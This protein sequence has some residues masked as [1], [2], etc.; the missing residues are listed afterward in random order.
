[1][2]QLLSRIGLCAS[3]SLL[4]LAAVTSVQAE[5]NNAKDKQQVW[6]EVLSQPVEQAKLDDASQSADTDKLTINEQRELIR[7]GM[8]VPKT[9]ANDR[10]MEDRATFPSSVAK[11]SKTSTKSMADDKGVESRDGTIESSVERY[12]EPA[13]PPGKRSKIVD[14]YIENKSKKQGFLASFTTKRANTDLRLEQHPPSDIPL[15]AKFQIANFGTYI[16]IGHEPTNRL[17]GY[18]VDFFGFN[19]VYLE[20]DYHQKEDFWTRWKIAPSGQEDWYLI[21]SYVEPK[22]CLAIGMSEGLRL[23]TCNIND[24]WQQFRFLREKADAFW[25]PKD[26]GVELEIL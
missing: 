6:D 9:K 17:I 19:H 16:R 18:H 26:E 4:S 14:I 12:L 2:Q 8:A 21:R 23:K 3:L 1:M 22:K 25:V 5:T 7:Q 13:T 20:K 10:I 24:E 11:S 15:E